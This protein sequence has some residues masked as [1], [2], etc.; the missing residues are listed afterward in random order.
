MDSGQYVNIQRL[1]KFHEGW[2]EHKSQGR[3]QWTSIWGVLRGHMIFLFSSK[4]T[5]PEMMIGTLTINK[6]TRLEKKDGNE[7]TGYRFDLYCAKRVNTFKTTKFSEREL[8]KAFIEGIARNTVP[9]SLDLLPGQIEHVREL[10]SIG[11]RLPSS[12]QI[13]RRSSEPAVVSSFSGGFDSP[14]GSTSGSYSQTDEDLN[15]PPEDYIEPTPVT[16]LTARHSFYADPSKTEPPRFALH[17]LDHNFH[18]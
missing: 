4:D 11:V 13:D 16:T 15:I 12:A 17:M 2:M 18:S 5:S 10:L 8:W 7:Q 6:D 3:R 14:N 1:K 9:D